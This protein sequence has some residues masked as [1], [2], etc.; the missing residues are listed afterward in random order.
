MIEDGGNVGA[1]LSA[2]ITSGLNQ[3]ITVD[4]EPPIV[5]VS[6][7]ES[8]VAPFTRSLDYGL[9]IIRIAVSA[10]DP[11]VRPRIYELRV[12]RQVVLEDLVL[13]GIKPDDPYLFDAFTRNY[14]VELSN[15]ST[16]LTVTPRIP[17]GINID[18]TISEGRN[19]IE[20]NAPADIGF[21]TS[22]TKVIT[23]ALE[24]PNDTTYSYTV[25]ATRDPSDIDDLAS[26]Q[27]FSGQ[28]LLLS[29]DD[30]SGVNYVENFSS[31]TDD[32]RLVAEVLNPFAMITEFEINPAVQQ[33]GGISS[34]KRSIDATITI[35]LRAS[36]AID[37]TVVAQDGMT[38]KTYEIG[39]TRVVSGDTA[40]LEGTPTVN[41]MPAVERRE[42]EYFAD[43]S[44]DTE[45][46]TIRATAR[47]PAGVVSIIDSGAEQ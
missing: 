15:Q 21:I 37:I 43:L 42:G 30:L 40:L 27:L 14:A 9:N 16:T 18:Y 17:V 23:I 35:G 10:Q 13:G 24:G 31:L 32:V 6:G 2:T 45:R 7:A 33:V 3:R 20:E 22:E 28:T 12:F 38:E 41:D 44:S 39:L 26:F 29:F 4:G 36:V 8:V 34:D 47:H 1:E 11:N 19:V 5:I 46:F 25:T